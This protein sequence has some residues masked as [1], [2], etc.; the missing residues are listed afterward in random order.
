MD[1]DYVDQST[2]A[3]RKDTTKRNGKIEPA[4]ATIV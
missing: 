3:Y 1:P 2:A 4:F